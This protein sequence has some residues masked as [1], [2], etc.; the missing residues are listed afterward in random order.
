MTQTYVCADC[1][2]HTKSWASIAKHLRQNNHIGANWLF[3]HLLVRGR[4]EDS[5][6][7]DRLRAKIEAVGR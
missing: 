7:I 6:E 5:E 2:F 4:P 1:P 3:G